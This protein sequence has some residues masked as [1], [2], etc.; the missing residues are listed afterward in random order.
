MTLSASTYLNGC[1]YSSEKLDLKAY[2]IWMSGEAKQSLMEEKTIGDYKF[3]LLY[4]PAAWIAINEIKRE[5]P[6]TDP[7][8]II[9]KKITELGTMNYFGLKIESS[10]LGYDPFKNVTETERQM[11]EQFF[12]YDLQKNIN[13]INGADTVPCSLYNYEYN[14]FPSAHIVL[15]LAFD[16]EKIGPL[17]KTILIADEV[18]GVGNIYITF[19]KEKIR[20]IPELNI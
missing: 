18:L 7:S 16:S 9:K 11:R 6:I 17:D 5:E 10:K 15:S 1:N 8:E 14:T 19:D 2:Q 4:K 20:K 3:T 13:L 12:L